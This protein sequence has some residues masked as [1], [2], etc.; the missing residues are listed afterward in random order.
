MTEHT[1]LKKNQRVIQFSYKNRSLHTH[2]K[3][4]CLETVS[5]DRILIIENPIHG[6]IFP[7]WVAYMC[8]LCIVWHVKISQ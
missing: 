2:M 3:S 6:Y 7:N 8:T 5:F 1:L 4:Q